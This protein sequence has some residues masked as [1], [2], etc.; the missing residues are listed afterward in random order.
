MG[1][2]TRTLFFV[3]GDY[4]LQDHNDQ[5]ATIGVG[6]SGD[7]RLNDAKTLCSGLLKFA[8]QHNGAF[9]VTA[10]QADSYLPKSLMPNAPEWQ[11]APMS[12]TNDFELVFR[13][14]LHEI[15]NIPLR[16][17]VVVRERSPWPTNDGKLARTYGFADGTASIVVSDDGFRSW[18]AQHVIPDH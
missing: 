9:P 10:E 8:E 13:G 11:D 2:A 4:A 1:G 14:S 7:G 18:D 15:T 3:A 5:V 6:R 17:I 12:G 16:R